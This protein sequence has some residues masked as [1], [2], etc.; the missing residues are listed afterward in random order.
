MGVAGVVVASC[1]MGVASAV[2]VV[3]AL[4]WW[5]QLPQRAPSS[6]I[7]REPTTVVW[8]TDASKRGHGGLDHA[9]SLE[10]FPVGEEMGD[11][12]LGLWTE[13]ESRM[14]ICALELRAF[15]IKLEECGSAVAAK[16]LLLLEDNMGVVYILRSF[17]TRS[18]EMESDLER[19]MELLEKWD[20]DL[21]VRYIP[22]KEN[23][24]R[25]RRIMSKS[26][27]TCTQ[28]VSFLN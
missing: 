18:L 16:G 20:I 15:R 4:E 26:S 27:T 6:K 10:G 7:W 19:V 28:Q 21:R 25:T 14:T 8:A 13:E 2:C 12:T 3:G 23:Q 17:V 24:K 1:L 11:A 22:S 5:A 9:V